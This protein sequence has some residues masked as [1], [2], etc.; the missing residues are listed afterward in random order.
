VSA[1]GMRK[2]V[3]SVKSRKIKVRKNGSYVGSLLG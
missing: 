3:T 2:E 1:N